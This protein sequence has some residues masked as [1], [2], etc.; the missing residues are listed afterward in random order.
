MFYTDFKFKSK[1]LK[2]LAIV[3]SIV[4]II[5]I[6]ASKYIGNF[7]IRLIMIGII[8]VVGIDL[9][10]TYKYTDKLKK[11]AYILALVG[12]IVSLFYPQL[13]VL[14]LGVVLLYFCAMSLYN[15]YKKN[16]F[17]NIIKLISTIIGVILSL[18]CIFNS[19]GI[20]SVVIKILGAILIAVGCFCFYQYINNNNNKSKLSLEDEYKFENAEEIKNDED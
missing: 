14:I 18:F 15:I 13:V 9:K 5:F 7:A 17:N 2:I 20:L 3:L 12:A 6:L 4:G 1:T 11:S 8:A 10:A 16:S 19:K